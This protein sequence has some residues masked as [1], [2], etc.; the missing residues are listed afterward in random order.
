[1]FCPMRLK[2]LGRTGL[3]VSELCLGAM[4][5]GGTADLA[6]SRRIVDAYRDAGGNF[7]D[8]ANNYGGGRSEEHLGEILA[9]RRDQVVL[10]TKYTAPIRADDPNSGG[11]HRKSL[12]Q[13][14]EQSLRRLRTDYVDLL[15]VHVWDF[16]T[17]V[18]E[19]MR[20]LDDQVRA[21]KVLYVGVSDVPAW[22]VAQANTLAELRG[23]TPFSALQIEYSL[24]ERTVERELIPMA[25]ALGLTVTA[26]GPL[27][28]GLLTGK[29]ADGAGEG[30]LEEG[31]RRMTERNHA[32][33]AS[34]VEVAADA[35]VTP[36]QAALA[37]LRSRAPAA[38]I[39]ILGARTADQLA[40]SLGCLDV[41]LSDDHL[42]RL[43]E[44]SAVEMGFPHDFL[45][46]LARRYRR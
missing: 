39:P 8:T 4:T 11:N 31:D 24:V 26:W 22:T 21:G 18:E 40:E 25:A 46:A 14:L 13:S 15:W 33:V 36:S 32:I 2:R 27:A 9:G 38:V 23:W 19:V 35:G 30:R 43:D 17:P 7:V 37:W 45:R 34:L 1:A 12:V 42:A 6:E 10:A 28:G 20:A 3:Q 41:E 44:A 16:G 29:Y 5:F